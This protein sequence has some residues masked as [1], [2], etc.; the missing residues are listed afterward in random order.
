MFA[1]RSCVAALL[2]ALLGAA[3]LPSTA[4]AM[5]SGTPPDG[6]GHPAVVALIYEFGPWGRHFCSGML[7]APRVVLT[8]SH[9]VEAAQNLRNNGWTLSVS[10][11]PTLPDDG[12]GWIAIPDLSTHRVVTTLNIN[13]QYRIVRGA[14]YRHD[15]SAMGLES[16]ID[17]PAGALPV[18][19][20]PGLL[21]ALRA[22]GE[23]RSAVFTVL[24]Y[25]REQKTLP[26]NSGPRHPRTHERRV[27]QLG[28]DALDPM[29][30]HQSQ[31]AV[32][33]WDGACYG[34]SGGPS[35]LV[36][37]GV[38]YVVAVTSTGDGPCFA[39]NVAART[40]R[41]DALE[42]LLDVLDAND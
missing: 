40:D 20:P 28:F 14:P 12:N 36:V 4:R 39:T 13:P 41:T 3:L 21:D 25:G 9:C 38:R 15:V 30:I 32:Q 27:G 24:G 31:R 19:P 23:L 37:G 42:L 7:I 17:L 22:S 10:N 11:D 33:G 1:G 18:L 29:F 35:L 34:D 8:A 26:A 2:A 5:N 16:P 6:T